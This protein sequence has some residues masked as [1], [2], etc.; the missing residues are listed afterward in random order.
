[1]AAHYR[2]QRLGAGMGIKPPDIFIAFACD[3]CHSAVDG[4]SHIDGYTKDDIRHAFLLGVLET[5][6]WLFDNGFIRVGKAK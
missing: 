3:C 4:R 5:Q 2:S 6:K 1:M